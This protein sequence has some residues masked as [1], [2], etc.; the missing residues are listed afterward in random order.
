DLHFL[1]V[2][3]EDVRL[4]GGQG[5]REC[6]AAADEDHEQRDSCCDV[7]HVCPPLR[8]IDRGQSWGER[9]PSVRWRCPVVNNVLG[10]NVLGA[11]LRQ[12][13]LRRY[14]VAAVAVSKMKG[15]LGSSIPN[16]SRTTCD[17]RARSTCSSDVRPPR[18]RISVSPR[19]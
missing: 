10:P 3:L 18:S 2:N 5:L 12:R 9:G 17:S 16:T 6:R 14:A 7:I 13:G 1:T 4:R 11:A 15:P 19:R 8:A